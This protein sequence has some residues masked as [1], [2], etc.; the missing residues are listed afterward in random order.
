MLRVPWGSM[1]SE[2][3]HLWDVLHDKHLE[4]G[5]GCNSFCK[6]DNDSAWDVAAW[7]D[8]KISGDTIAATCPKSRLI[9]AVQVLVAG[10]L[11]MATRSTPGTLGVLPAAAV[12]G[13]V[14]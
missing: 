8:Q 5:F 14:L 12:R 10:A 11:P 6:V 7:L 2:L 3:H 1:V 9:I 4:S 13:R